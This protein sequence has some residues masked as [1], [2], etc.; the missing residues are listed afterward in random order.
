MDSISIEWFVVVNPHAGSGKTVEEWTL[1]DRLLREAGISYNTR[2]TE[3]KSHA[4]KLAR[5]AAAA[6]YRR[7]IAVG[8]D[9]SVHE[10]MSGLAG[11]AREEGIA[12]EEFTLGVIPIGSGNDWI[13][14]LG[15]PHD[16][17]SVVRLMAESPSS[18]EDVVRVAT[19]DCPETYMA[20]IGGVGFDSRVCVMVNAQKESGHR[21]KLIYIKALLRTIAEMKRFAVQV[22]ADGDEIYSGPCYSMAFGNGRYCGGGLIQTPLAD[23]DDG[24]LDVM[25][26]PAQSISSLLP[27]LPKILNG[28]INESPKVIYRRCRHLF[29]VPL[30]SE[31]AKVPVEVDGEIEG[32]LPLEI[33]VTSS[34]INVLSGK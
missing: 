14:S 33:T 27:L 9:G 16:T 28:S 8:G 1:A 20:N 13:R 15:V 4:V 30:D 7:F 11:Y 32:R 29:V 3:Y 23:M 22:I 25:I 19:K 26:V 18:R 6:G 5:T 24:L 21:S 2:F 10:L 34:K 31:A 12:T 17:A